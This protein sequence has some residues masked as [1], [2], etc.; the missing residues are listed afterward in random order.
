MATVGLHKH[1][2]ISVSSALVAESWVRVIAGT[3]P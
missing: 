2:E 1:L 3:E